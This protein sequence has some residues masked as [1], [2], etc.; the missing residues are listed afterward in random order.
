MD[1]EMQNIECLDDYINSLD[2]EYSQEELK[3]M[4]EISH[5]VM[6]KCKG[7]WREFVTYTRIDV[8]PD[9]EGC[10]MRRPI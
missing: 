6:Q 1:K 8:H 5:D 7:D 4:M 2:G 10:K 3:E 9:H